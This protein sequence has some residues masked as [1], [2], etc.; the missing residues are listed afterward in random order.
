MAIKSDFALQIASIVV[1][2]NRTTGISYILICGVNTRV[3]IIPIALLTSFYVS[4][5][6]AFSM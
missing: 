4:I 5:S 6:N 1:G 2:G 3:R